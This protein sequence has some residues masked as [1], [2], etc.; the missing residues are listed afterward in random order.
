L[1][2]FHLNNG[3]KKKDWFSQREIHKFSAILSVEFLEN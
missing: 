1:V 3:M 2:S